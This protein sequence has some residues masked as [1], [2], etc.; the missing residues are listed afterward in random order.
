MGALAKRGIRPADKGPVTTSSAYL[1]HRVDMHQPVALCGV[2]RPKFHFKYHE[3][4]PATRWGRLVGNCDCC[5]SFTND[6]VMFVHEQFVANSGGKEM[7]GQ[8]YTPE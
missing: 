1:M 4:V 3:Y 2:C 6:Q 8:I 5:K 7:A